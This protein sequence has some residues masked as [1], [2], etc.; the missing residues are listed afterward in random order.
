MEHT[1]NITEKNN[2]L[3][4]SLL[5]AFAMFEI[6]LSDKEGNLDVLS[7]R[8]INCKRD[9]GLFLKINSLIFD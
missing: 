4:S 1:E 8:Y 7:L 2:G 6:R 3:I 9:I 5:K